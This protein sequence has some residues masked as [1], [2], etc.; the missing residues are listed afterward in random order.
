[1]VEQKFSYKGFTLKKGNNPGPRYFHI[2][3][4]DN[5]VGWI[6]MVNDDWHFI[7]DNYP[8]IYEG[9]NPSLTF[10]FLSEYSEDFQEF[11]KLS[12]EFIQKNY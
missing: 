7:M 1:M 11:L 10:K 8:S 3:F 4:N 12:F 9:F 5:N 6:Q 2:Y